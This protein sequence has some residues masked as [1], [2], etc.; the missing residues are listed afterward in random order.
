VNEIERLTQFIAQANRILIFTGAGMSTESGLP[1]F[2]G[3]GGMWERFK[4]V[5]I[6][7]FLASEEHRIGYW[8]YKLAFMKHLETA[9]PNI[10]HRAIVE[11]ER[12][13]K[14][15]G[16]VTQNIDG[17]HEMA[18]SSKEKIL[19]I[20]G[21][22]RETICLS[23]GEIRPWTEVY[24]RLKAGEKI[25]LCSSCSGLLKPNTISFGQSLDP[26]VLNEA[27]QWMTACDLLLALGSTLVV[28]PAASLPVL[29]KQHGAK[30]V[31]ITLSET[32]LDSMADLKISGKVGE[33]LSQALESLLHPG[34]RK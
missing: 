8:A 30:L 34:G 17:L 28:E 1:D 14:L 16:I 4:A 10:G 20:H 22:T 3:K 18:G 13:E 19:E 33:V 5:T 11:L 7:E 15:K 12:M 26:A 21:T 2:R 27:A 32:P 23:C 6:Q 25:P 29:A 24:Q 31:I 9:Q